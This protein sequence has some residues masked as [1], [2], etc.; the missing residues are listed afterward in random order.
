[1]MIDMIADSFIDSIRL[2]PFLFLTYLAMEFLEH[3]AGESMQAVIR[4]AGK[5]GPL[6][7][8]ILGIFPQCGFSTAASNLYAGRIITMG[9]LIAVYLSTSD[10]MLPIMISSNAAL[11][12]IVKI[13]A[14]KAVV[15]AA[16]GYAVDGICH[17]DKE[18]MQI[19]HLCEQHHCHCEDGI[20]KSALRHTLEIFVFILLISLVLNGL[21][22]WVGED[23]LSSLILDRPILGPLVAGL[24]GFIPNCAASVII[25]Q[26]YLE[27][28]LGTGSLIAGLLTGTGVGFLVLLHVNSHRREN[29]GIAGILYA[30]GVL[31][32]IVLEL[33]G[34]SF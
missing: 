22:A 25:T 27:G 34:V 18:D 24:I 11:P 15:A 30:A 6:I 7:G 16:V 14:V 28:M 20:G 5:G 9:T 17:R 13:L 32:G 23:A 2:L 31:A 12:S 10:E 33:A 3:K 19:G 4:R 29:L 26:L 21:I 8:S 1:M